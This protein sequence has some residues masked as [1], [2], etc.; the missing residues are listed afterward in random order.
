M[1][2]A[3]S[4]KGVESEASKN[5]K[6][7]MESVNPVRLPFLTIPALDTATIAEAW[8]AYA[9]YYGELTAFHLQR[10]N[11]PHTMDIQHSGQK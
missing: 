2:A 7:I 5:V 1:S 10:F 6:E 4:S 3:E 11:R 9:T 8:A